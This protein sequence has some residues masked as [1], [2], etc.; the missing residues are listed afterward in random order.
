MKFSIVLRSI[1]VFCS[2][3]AVSVRIVCVLYGSIALA[4]WCA[5]LQGVTSKTCIIYV[6]GH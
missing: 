1:S 4:R 2:N 3:A 6:T 5:V